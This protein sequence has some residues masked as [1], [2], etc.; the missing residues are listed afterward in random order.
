[1][2]G[3][4]FIL[5]G[6][7]IIRA[8]GTPEYYDSIG[9]FG[10]LIWSQSLSVLTS[11][12]SLGPEISKKTNYLFLVSIG[13]FILLVAGVQVCTR[14]FG[15]IG[16]GMGI[17][18][19]QLTRYISQT[20]LSLKLLGIKYSLLNDIIFNLLIILCITVSVLDI[21]IIFRIISSIIL[22]YVFIPKELKNLTQKYLNKIRE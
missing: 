13:A 10:L 21:S 7:E 19:Y 8:I 15:L 22:I 1:L 14:S 11:F 16:V 5:F 17:L 6:K 3:I 4:L 20:I 2:G 18:F 12:R 9:V